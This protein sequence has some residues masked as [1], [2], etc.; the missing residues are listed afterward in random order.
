MGS[1]VVPSVLL[2]A[3]KVAEYRSSHVIWEQAEH[4]CVPPLPSHFEIGAQDPFSLKACPLRNYLGYSVLGIGRQL[5]PSQLE[6]VK[7][8]PGEKYQPS[9]RN[10]STTCPWGSPITHVSDP[11]GEDSDLD[12]AEKSST[13][14]IDDG[15]GNSVA[16]SQHLAMRGQPCPGVGLG[17]GVSDPSPAADLRVLTGSYQCRNVFFVPSPQ[18]HLIVAQT[19]CLQLN[20]DTHTANASPRRSRRPPSTS[21]TWPRP[22]G[23]TACAGAAGPSEAQWCRCE[24]V[25]RKPGH[26]DLRARGRPRVLARERPASPKR[27]RPQD[28]RRGCIHSVPASSQ[29]PR[30][31]LASRQRGTFAV[32]SAL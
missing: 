3:P 5:N 1:E 11:P 8:P 25:A 19:W 15:E 20:V 17:V 4:N 16:C 9:R 32:R 10:T 31:R 13:T 28:G 29:E 7:C 23:S 24:G 2:M 27:P 21:A 30:L 26:S 22:S 12:R 18:H 6:G 14:D